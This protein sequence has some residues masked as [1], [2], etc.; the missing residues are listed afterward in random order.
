MATR[1][2]DLE[3]LLRSEITPENAAELATKLSN[4]RLRD[5]IRAVERTP[6]FDAAVIFRLLTKE[7]ASK[8]F[9]ALDTRH[10]AALVDALNREDVLD[11]FDHLDPDDR[12]SLLDELADNVAEELVNT[13]TADERHS[14]GIIL[15]YPKGTVGRSMSP[16]VLP[17]EE[18][19]TVGDALSIIQNRADEM[20]TIYTIPV[21]DS[22][23]HLT[24][25]C[26]MK[27][28][29][30]SNPAE[31]LSDIMVEPV[32][33][34]ATDDAELTA[35]WMRPL[36][37]LAMPVVDSEDKLVGILTFEDA[38]DILE[39]AE[40][41]DSARH[42]AHEPLQKPYLVTP[43][44]EVVKSRIVWLLVLAISAL[45]TVQVL[46]SFES[47]LEKAVTLALFIPLLTGTAGNTGN[48]AA[49]TVT[50][51]LA[52]GD[53]Q[54]RDA[55]RVLWR[56]MRT[57]FLLGSVLG[58]IGFAAASFFYSPHI[59]MVMGLTLVAVCTM[60][61][62]VGG[63]MPI[64]AKTI[65]AD[66]AVFSNPFISTVSDATGLLIYFLIAKAVLGI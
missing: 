66:P 29:L 62:A 3:E 50:R 34:H 1:V 15:A 20:E 41:E 45:L 56:E 60:S 38:A 6:A 42:G 46:E 2:T 27:D 37:H 12:V 59:G 18:T 30:T 24:G 57:G 9:D 63:V 31:R 22:S 55:F 35:R 11:Y 26:S 10:Q 4:A 36:N 58:T 61:A 32:L 25:I 13:L 8:V 16:E 5:V 21:V 48:Q 64:V 14:I 39:E 23:R 19:M 47:T 51:S 40:S 49:T 17:F 52:L 53:V 44:L 54:K 7:R 65:G 43:V 28:L 33:A